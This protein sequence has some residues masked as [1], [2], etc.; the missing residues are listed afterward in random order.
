[1]RRKRVE[2]CLRLVLVQQCPYSILKKHSVKSEEMRGGGQGPRKPDDKET[3]DEE[4]KERV[5]KKKGKGT[6]RREPQ[7]QK[8]HPHNS[9]ATSYQTPHN[10][11]YREYCGENIEVE[12]YMQP[13][14]PSLL[15]AVLDGWREGESGGGFEAVV[16]RE[17]GG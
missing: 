9:S 11:D 10:R 8:S 17:I 13:Q 3:L 12:R 7:P 5:K 14:V 1:M 15:E 6:H 16:C 2:S 4:V